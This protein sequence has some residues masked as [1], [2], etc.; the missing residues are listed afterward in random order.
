LNR[1][2][3]DEH[4]FRFDE[5]LLQRVQL[6]SAL[7]LASIPVPPAGTSFRPVER[8]PRAQFGVVG[9]AP[10]GEDDLDALLFPSADVH[11]R[12]TV[13]PGLVWFTTPQPAD[14]RGVANQPNCLGCHTN[15]GESLQNSGLVTTN[16]PASR[17]ARSTPTNLDVTGL[18]IAADTDLV[19]NGGV[20]DPTKSGRTAAFTIF[21]DFCAASVPCPRT[22]LP[23][24][25]PGAFDGLAR[26]PFFGVVQHTRPSFPP[27][28][29]PDPLPPL[30]PPDAN[31]LGLDP[32]NGWMNDWASPSGFRRQVAERAAPP[33]LGRGL[34]ETIPDADIEAIADPTDAENHTSSLDDPAAFP[35][36]TGDCISGRPNRNTA[37]QTFTGGDPVPRLGRFGLRA[38]GPQLRQFDA[39]GAQEEVGVTSLLRPTDNIGPA[40]CQDSMPEPELPMTTT[41]SL[42]SLI[43]LTTIPE[44]GDTLL[45][46]LESPDPAASQ[47]TGSAAARVQRGARL[48]GIDLEAFANRMIP[49]RIPAAG[50]GRDPHAI[51]QG[52]RML[53]C[54]GCH[55]PIQRTGQ[56]AAD[57]GA[58]HLTHVWA[59]VFS[60]MLLHSMPVI[61]AERFAPTP[62][63]P[64]VIQHNG[65]DTFDIRRN[66]G[67]DALPNQG[68]ARGDEFRTAPLMALGRIG[69]PYIH[70]VRVYL[71]QHTFQNAP[72]GTVA[73]NSAATNAPLIVRSLDDAIRA[74]IEVHDLPPP[75]AGCPVPPGGATRVGN[76]VYVDP[77]DPGATPAD[78][79]CPSYES[80]RSRTRRG[81]AREVIGRYRALSGEDQQSLID[82]LKEL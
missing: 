79:I 30:G 56:S 51:N 65:V 40:V 20:N 1:D 64:L 82:F 61:D 32:T 22:G 48:F 17:A 6:E 54:A 11:V 59:P 66:F 31:L 4:L 50:D 34:M 75:G 80:D 23:P 60:D 5:E 15:S 78:L 9:P 33:Y 63:L 27:P 38:Q 49:G 45:G 24:I 77:D 28:C 43:R 25:N 8:I 16:S 44:F 47:P 39:V 58:E 10:L 14:I 72:A 2:P 35:E 29:L 52:D 26:A 69:P 12:R 53:N 68:L 81:E 19:I 67:E 3:T 36:C 70:D 62:R 46:L 21:G 55:T 76:I 74:A 57:V 41:F 7:G 18:G 42:T 37:N 13:M 73:T 71:T